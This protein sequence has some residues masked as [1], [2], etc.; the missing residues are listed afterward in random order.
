MAKEEFFMNLEN[1]KIMLRMLKDIPFPSDQDIKL[2]DILT[3]EIALER[4]ESRPVVYE[5]L[6]PEEIS[7]ETKEKRTVFEWAEDKIKERMGRDSKNRD[8]N[9]KPLLIKIGCAIYKRIR[10]QPVTQ[11]E[12]DE[13][14]KKVVK[15]RLKADIAKSKAVIANSKGGKMDTLN[16]LFG[17]NRT[18]G[19]KTKTGYRPREYDIDSDVLSYRHKTLGYGAKRKYL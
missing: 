16:K 4:T 6:P 7:E 1:K 12:L 10:E 15:Y 5:R 3:E 19:K 2:I 14:K 8:P 18:Q 9:R 13:L 11:A 17:D